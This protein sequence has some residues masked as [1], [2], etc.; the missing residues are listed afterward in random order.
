MIKIEIIN[1]TVYG[2]NCRLI[3]DDKTRKAFVVDPGG[4]AELIKSTAD[5]LD[6]T[7]EKILITHGHLD[8]IG[9]VKIL[10]DLTG[11]KIIGPSIEEKK[12]ISSLPTQALMLGL[13]L[14]EGFEFESVYD[15]EQIEILK[16]LFLKV[17]TTPGHTKGGVCYYCEQERFLLS[18]DTLFC[19]SIGRT[20]FPGGSYDE[21]ISS[22]KEKLLILPDET[23]VLSGHG[24]DS[25]IGY[26]RSYNPFCGD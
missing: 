18:G 1:V 16:D 10:Q 11:A 20:D 26:E 5:K 21:I 25:T 2:Q 12:L 7:I 15:G 9:A 6:L 19:G 22:I 13:P 3:Y 14:P 24:E 8:H 17:I 23:K 4:N